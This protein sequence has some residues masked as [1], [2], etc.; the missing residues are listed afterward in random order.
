MGL[1]E[2]L[3]FGT[4]PAQK[5]AGGPTSQPTMLT[6]D[7]PVGHHDPHFGKYWVNRLFLK[8]SSKTLILWLEMGIVEP[9]A[10]TV[11]LLKCHGKCK[12]KKSQEKWAG[13]KAGFQNI[14]GAGFLYL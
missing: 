1:L 7:S 12:K 3:L 5:Q 13:P 14:M 8:V 10:L 9:A 11:V 6:H 2:R 4:N